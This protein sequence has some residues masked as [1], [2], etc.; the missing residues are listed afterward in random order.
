MSNLNIKFYFASP[1][2]VV[3]ITP[4]NL[5]EAADWCGGKVAKTESNRVPGRMDSYVWVPTP[6]GSG[7]SWA[8]PGMFITKRLAVSEKGQLKATYAVFR[9]DYFNRNY[10]EEMTQAVDATWER[11]A[12][13]RKKEKPAQNVVVNVF[14][15][16]GVTP[17]EVA[18]VVEEAVSTENI[19]A[20]EPASQPP[21][22]EFSSESAPFVGVSIV[23]TPSIVEQRELTREAEVEAQA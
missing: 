5:Q 14:P 23:E 22:L 11:E 6:K 9:K 3:R 4:H 7:V 8:F 2:E 10:F 1:V 17:A 20:E 16:E 15:A 12:A 21:M 19:R 18:R 13:E